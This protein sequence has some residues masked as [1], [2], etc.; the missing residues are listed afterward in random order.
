MGCLE[1]LRAEDA[2]A[3]WSPDASADGLHP[4]PRA[5]HDAR[6]GTA[7]AGVPESSRA[8]APDRS[9]EAAQQSR[10]PSA[11]E[12]IAAVAPHKQAPFAGT[13]QLPGRPVSAREKP[14]HP[15]WHPV[16]L[17]ALVWR[18]SPNLLCISLP[19]DHAVVSSNRAS[20]GE[21]PDFHSLVPT[22][23]AR[24]AAHAPPA[25]SHTAE[26]ASRWH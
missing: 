2:A 18:H 16:P 8:D 13:G 14:L 17:A 23:P 21:I 19:D 15:A 4:S 10:Q 26:L 1:H 12:C 22:K 3:L 9:I 24:R 25:G 11:E 6:N 20:P 5:A 7:P